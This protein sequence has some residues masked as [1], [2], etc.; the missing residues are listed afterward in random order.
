[1]LTDGPTFVRRRTEMGKSWNIVGALLLIVGACGDDEL[2]TLVPPAPICN[3]GSET[4]CTCQSGATGTMPCTQN[5]Q[6]FGDC[7]CNGGDGGVVPVA[8]SRSS[9]DAAH[10]APP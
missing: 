9:V 8:A 2:S 5:G 3:P 4:A 10:A 7:E 1:M 6:A